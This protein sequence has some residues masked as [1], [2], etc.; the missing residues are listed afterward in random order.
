MEQ[1]KADRNKN[2]RNDCV[3]K[4]LK[5]L[6]KYSL[7]F[8]SEKS[9][10]GDVYILTGTEAK[11]YIRGSEAISIRPE[12]VPYQDADYFLFGN[13]EEGLYQFGSK[14][15]LTNLEGKSYSLIN[16]Y[17]CLSLDQVAK[18]IKTELGLSSEG[19]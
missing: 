4:I 19:E 2:K 5:E 16:D 7:D 15:Q 14:D 11:I 17:E 3:N 6:K 13:L 10:K 12:L 18:K 8:T 9:G 1:S